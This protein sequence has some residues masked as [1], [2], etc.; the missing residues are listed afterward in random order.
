MNNKVRTLLSSILL[1]ALAVIP[2]NAQED[3]FSININTNSEEATEINQLAAQYLVNGQHFELKKLY[4][5]KADSLAPM[6]HAFS[7]AELLSVFNRNEEA[8]PAIRHFINEH[9][10]EIPTELLLKEFSTAIVCA[11]IIGNHAE[12]RDMAANVV[13]MLKQAS[14]PDD[15]IQH[16]TNYYNSNAILATLPSQTIEKKKAECQIPF[17]IQPVGKKGG[18]HMLVNGTINGKPTGMVFDTGAGCSMITRRKAEEFGLRMSD[19]TTSINAGGSVNAVYGTIDSLV[20]GD[21]VY[22]NVLCAVNDFKTGNA[23]A[24]SVIKDLDLVLGLNV[25]R[26]LQEF[27]FDFDAS[28]I[29]IPSAPHNY[30]TPNMRQHIQ[31]RVFEL[32]FTHNGM[33]IDA[34]LD[35]GFAGVLNLDS[36]F[37]EANKEEVMANGEEIEDRGAGLAGVY[38][39]KKYLLKDFNFR[40]N[41]TDYTVAKAAVATKANEERSAIENN[42]FGLDAMR[43]FRRVTISLKDCYIGLEK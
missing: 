15:Y 13:G 25:M 17:I 9:R 14:A 3:G 19:A 35:S 2:A 32:T 16:F 38:I 29:I 22:R 21:L 6:V 43:S 34:I 30:P 39:Q 1:I 28:A 12:A 41:D 5:A 33:P 27:T 31:S 18:H 23:E 4:D 26:P 24:D 8:I 11:E 20:V 42:L 7:E 36:D 40:L 10:S 37:L